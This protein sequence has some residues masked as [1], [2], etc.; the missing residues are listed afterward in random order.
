MT[1]K[2]MGRRAAGRV[3][4]Q[5]E[6]QQLRVRKTNPHKLQETV[7]HAECV[8]ATVS[9]ALSVPRPM[10]VS[11]TEYVW[12]IIQILNAKLSQ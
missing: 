12:Q 5:K 2:G 6:Q 10:T 4:M 1:V 9:I 8:S 7:T 11:S 3:M